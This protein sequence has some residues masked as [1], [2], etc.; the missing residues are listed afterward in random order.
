MRVFGAPSLLYVMISCNIVSDATN[1]LQHT[2][3]TVA[4]YADY[5]SRTHAEKCR[6]HTQNPAT[7]PRAALEVQTAGLL[8]PAKR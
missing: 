3:Y 6:Q 8:G 2:R 7:S 4:D 5:H 1:I